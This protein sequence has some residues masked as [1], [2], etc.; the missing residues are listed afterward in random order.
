M[1]LNLI[2]LL[3]SK[4]SGTGFYHKTNMDFSGSQV[5]PATGRKRGKEQKMGSKKKTN[6]RQKGGRENMRA[7]KATGQLISWNPHRSRFPWVFDPFLIRIRFWTFAYFLLRSWGSLFYPDS[8]S[9]PVN[10]F[11]VL[12]PYLKEKV[13]H[14]SLVFFRCTNGRLDSVYESFIGKLTRKLILVFT[15]PLSASQRFSLS[16]IVLKK[17]FFSLR[18]KC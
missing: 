9:F 18:V 2:R 4:F 7:K 11:L 5:L 13:A 3:I 8:M 15:F 6:K 1:G 14:S 12:C 16:F 17:R 10:L